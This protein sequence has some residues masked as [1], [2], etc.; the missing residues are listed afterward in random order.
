MTKEHGTFY[1]TF[2]GHYSLSHLIFWRQ[3][4]SQ[5]G[6]RAM[7]GEPAVADA[8]QDYT[9][10]FVALIKEGALLTRLSF[11]R[12]RPAR[13]FFFGLHGTW[14]SPWAEA[15]C[16]AGLRPCRGLGIGTSCLSYTVVWAHYFFV[17]QHRERASEQ[18]Q[19]AARNQGKCQWWRLF[20]CA[21]C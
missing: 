13:P 7:S 19:A 5:R 10:R 8:L 9:Q 16:V 18:A 20:V 3:T 6:R 14:R 2:Y 11:L 12:A 21:D 15:I 4:G 1:G 17:R